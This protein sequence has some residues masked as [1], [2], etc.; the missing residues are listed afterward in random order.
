M[1]KTHDKATTAQ[2]NNLS[3]TMANKSNLSLTKG[4][5]P[6]RLTIDCVA[7]L[8]GSL[9]A[10]EGAPLNMYEESNALPQASDIMIGLIS[11]SMVIIH[12]Y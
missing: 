1:Q 12:T 10:R 4:A 11:T 5:E 2:V 7:A 8:P 3:P 9:V 6:V